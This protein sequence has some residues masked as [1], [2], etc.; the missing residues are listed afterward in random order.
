MNRVIDLH[1]LVLMYVYWCLLRFSYRIIFVSLVEQELPNLPEPMS[2]PL[3]FYVVRVAQ[4]LFE[5]FSNIFY[6]NNKFHK[7]K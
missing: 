6:F 1:L 3:V 5:P 4:S 7:K 2:S